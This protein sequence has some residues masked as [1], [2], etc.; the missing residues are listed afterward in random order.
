MSSNEKKQNPSSSLLKDSVNKLSESR[1]NNK[2]TINSYPQS[3]SSSSLSLSVS[4]Q[5]KNS[6]QESSTNKTTNLD[7]SLTNLDVTL[8]D[9]D[10]TIIDNSNCKLTCKS[11]ESSPTGNTSMLSMSMSMSVSST[12]SSS[13]LMESPST[14]PTKLLKPPPLPPKPK[15]LLTNAAKTNHLLSMK[16][17]TR[18]TTITSDSCENKNI[19]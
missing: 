9:A 2:S 16:N 18:T 12:S 1:I 17:N 3:P 14:S 5:Y 10:K 8:E 6:M 7:N 11:I 15:G 13:G 19:F 4:D